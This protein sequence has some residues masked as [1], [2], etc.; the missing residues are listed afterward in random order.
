MRI[1]NH[2][3]TSLRR[4]ER[5]WRGMAAAKPMLSERREILPEYK[6]HLSFKN[7]LLH[8]YAYNK[9]GRRGLRADQVT[10]GLNRNTMHQRAPSVSH[11]SPLEHCSNPILSGEIRNL[12]LRCSGSHLH[13]HAFDEP[14]GYVAPGR[15]TGSGFMA[16]G[17]GH[18]HSYGDM[19][20]PFPARIRDSHIRE[21]PG[22]LGNLAAIAEGRP[23]DWRNPYGQMMGAKP[24]PQTF[25]DAPSI[26]PGLPTGLSGHHPHASR[27]PDAGPR[28]GHQE[29][30]SSELVPSGSRARRDGHQL[31]ISAS[32]PS[33]Q[34][35]NA[36]PSGQGDTPMPQP[37]PSRFSFPIPFSG[38][39]LRAACTA[40]AFS[41]CLL[42]AAGRLAPHARKSIHNPNANAE[43]PI[44]ANPGQA[45][46]P[47][48]APRI[49]GQSPAI[50][51]AVGQQARKAFQLKVAR[52]G[53]QPPE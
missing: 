6:P 20:F 19:A 38:L 10:G 27:V 21:N 42:R 29:W 18:P 17:L 16:F 35:I 47:R 4:E 46:A 9:S 36:V 34:S 26:I 53:N 44:L 28:P 52:A 15:G 12:A 49:P 45:E 48:R 32:L 24:E 25:A 41:D 3:T 37:G 39:L 2:R 1:L 8:K 23:A 5:T 40:A 22:F 30:N 51:P 50:K 14:P 7:P 11:S 43:P 31:G 33:A 13:G